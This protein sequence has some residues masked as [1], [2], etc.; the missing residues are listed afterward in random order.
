M[1]APYSAQR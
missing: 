1:P